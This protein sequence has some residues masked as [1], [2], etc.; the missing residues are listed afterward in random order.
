M[1]RLNSIGGGR[2][3]LSFPRDTL[4]GDGGGGG[5]GDV[6]LSREP[7]IVSRVC[8]HRRVV[9]LYHARDTTKHKRT[10]YLRRLS[11]KE[12]ER[13]RS[14]RAR[15]VC[16]SPQ[17][18]PS[19]SSF[20]ISQSSGVAERINSRVCLVA[21]ATLRFLA[22]CILYRDFIASYRARRQYSCEYSEIPRHPISAIQSR[23]SNREFWRNIFV[24]FQPGTGI[25]KIRYTCVSQNR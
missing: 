19:V 17:S 14:A 18:S 2:A 22:D 15:Q 4:G 16:S 6:K 20:V 5:G 25:S 13:D 11:P 1:W 8:V 21:F 3:L 10:R 12:R 24:L 23:E 7:N 9:S